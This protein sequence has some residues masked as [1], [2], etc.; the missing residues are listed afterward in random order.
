MSSGAPKS[1]PKSIEINPGDFQLVFP[2]LF[3][4]TLVLN[5]CCMHFMV[6]QV[7]GHPRIIKKQSKP[8]PTNILKLYVAIAASRASF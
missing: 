7:L 2:M 3:C 6:F 1:I 4:R 8:S 5:D